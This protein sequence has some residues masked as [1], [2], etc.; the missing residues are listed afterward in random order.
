MSRDLPSPLSTTAIDEIW[1]SVAR[2][3]GFE[4]QRSTDCYAAS[5]GKG[6]IF[7]GVPEILDVDDSFAQLVFHEL[8]HAFVEGW[9]SQCLPD[10]GLDV[11]GGA[12]TAREHACLR[13]QAHLASQ[14][15][16]RALMAPT[17]EYRDYYESIGPQALGPQAL[18]PQALGPQALG[19]QALGEEASLV[20]KDD[21][22]VAIARVALASPAPAA[23]SWIL[24][25]QQALAT[26]ASLLGDA[27]VDKHPLGFALGPA[28]ETCASCAWFYL[29]G[30][31]PAVER[32]R[33][34]SSA[35]KNESAART[36][37]HFAAC[38]K[39]ESPVDC[40]TC[41]AC[42][43]E[44]Y[45]VVSV[46]MRDPVVWKQPDLIVRRGHRFEILRAGDRCAALNVEESTAAIT[47]N[48]SGI[49]VR[50]A[51]SRYRCR[52]YQDR[53]TTCRDF[54]AG[55]NHCL[56]ARQRLGLSR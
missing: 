28:N 50:P 25:L 8:C 4:L 52:I 30:R 9:H 15:K 29:G 11:S 23:A 43:R 38:E 19:E 12:D 47:P 39:W 41:G 18:G 10:W 22:A 53:P 33:Q 32:C 31:G 5:D 2:A 45:H 34:K 14:F 21:P 13:V 26:T 16:L 17:T 42:C 44:A 51:S 55:G 24:T 7:I 20:A 49:V 40:E 27:S 46:S 37:R 48:E 1:S 6:R 35:Q 3:L 56:S 54:S 36:S